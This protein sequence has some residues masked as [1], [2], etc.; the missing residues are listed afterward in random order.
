MRGPIPALVLFL[1]YMGEELVL[2]RPSGWLECSLHV[3][4]IKAL[5]GGFLEILR[6]G[7]FFFASF[8]LVQ[9]DGGYCLFSRDTRLFGEVPFSSS[10]FT[11]RYDS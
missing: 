5:M 3:R 6:L 11:V 8:F 2:V 10:D 9:V 7:C 1:E 4:V